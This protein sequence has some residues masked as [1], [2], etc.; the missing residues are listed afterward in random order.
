M[1][2]R[3][4]RGQIAERDVL[5]TFVP[6]FFFPNPR[7][8]KEM[9]KA[10][11]R[12]SFKWK[13]GLGN[14]GSRCVSSWWFRPRKLTIAVGL[15]FTL[16]CFSQRDA[17][18]EGDEQLTLGSSSKGCLISFRRL[19]SLQCHSLKGG[20]KHKWR[21]CTAFWWGSFICWQQAKLCF[22]KFQAL[23]LVLAR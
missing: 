7:R 23:Q 16:G 18:R 6:C 15:A 13:A 4:W 17:S 21:R 10:S 11:L 22:S 2:A 19:C 8:V 3:T 5:P 12:S 20:Q 14:S 1:A 9:E